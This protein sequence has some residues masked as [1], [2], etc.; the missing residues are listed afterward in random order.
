M[1]R[2]GFSVALM[3]LVASC[4][5]E[6]AI[7]TTTER[8]SVISGRIAFASDREGNAEV[9]VM[10]ADGSNQVDLTNDPTEQ[11]NLARQRPE[12]LAELQA[13][14]AAHNAEQLEPAWPSAGSFPINI[15]KDLSIPDAPDDEYIYWSN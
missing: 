9:Y 15:D 1:R 3:L 12:K 2:L 14:L 4:G 13:A 6:G 8:E 11:T 7:T 5:G 10:D